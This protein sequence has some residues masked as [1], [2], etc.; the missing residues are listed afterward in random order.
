MDKSDVDAFANI[1]ILQGMETND[2][3]MKIAVLEPS[4]T[5]VWLFLGDMLSCDDWAGRIPARSFWGEI[6]FCTRTARCWREFCFVD[7]IE[8]N[9]VIIVALLPPLFCV[10]GSCLSAYP[11]TA[12]CSRKRFLATEQI[13]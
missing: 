2:D 8:T 7:R 10:F 5:L 9:I 1:V 3:G 13:I 6:P 4:Q 12:S 11:S